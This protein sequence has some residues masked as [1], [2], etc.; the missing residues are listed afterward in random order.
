MLTVKVFCFNP[1]QENTYI[2]YNEQKQAVVID[3]G[4]HTAAEQQTVVGFIAQNGLTPVRLINTHC[5]IDHVLGN[6][7]IAKTYNLGLEI[8]ELETENLEK[9]VPYGEMFGLV[10]APQPTPT[11]YLTAHDTI[12]L[13]AD[14]LQVIFTPGHSAGSVSLYC[15]AQNFVISGDVLF[16][17]SIGRTDLPGGSFVVL[18]ESI[19]QK[20]YSL[21]PQ[22]KVYSG[23]GNPTSIGYEMQHNPYIKA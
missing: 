11:S 14:E 10:V 19:T 18:K 7:F 5:H 23:H 15:A 22:T 3:P 9:A 21:P 20:M 12:V 13:G 6:N 16:F 8:H 1:F 17:E 4:C 2:L